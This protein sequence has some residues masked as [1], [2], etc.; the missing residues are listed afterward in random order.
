MNNIINRLPP[1]NAALMA[2]YTKYDT[3]DVFQ[4]N[5]LRGAI[6]KFFVQPNITMF[7]EFF[8]ILSEQTVSI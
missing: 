7:Q 3:S 4:A 5:V 8:L 6:S 2:V 1:I